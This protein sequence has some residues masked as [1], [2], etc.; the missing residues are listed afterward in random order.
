MPAPKNLYPPAPST[1]RGQASQLT[2]D[3]HHDRLGYVSLNN[4]VIRSATDPLSPALAYQE[5]TYRPTACRFSP[6]GGYMASG[7]LS[8]LVKVWS[9]DHEDLVLKMEVPCIGGAIKDVAWSGDNQRLVAV[10]DGSDK[11]GHAFILDTGTSVGEIG[12]H[13]KRI[14]TCDFKPTR[15]FRVVTGAED[16]QVNFHEGPPFK[17]KAL[18]RDHTRFVNCVRFSPD[19]AALLSVGSD[20]QGLI[21]DG[22]DFTRTG[23][24][25]T[26][27]AHKG[28]IF[29]CAWSLDGARVVTGSGDKTVKLWDAATG[30]C[31]GTYPVGAGAVRDMQVG[32]IFTKD[33]FVSL[34]LGG[35]LNFFDARVEGS[36][37][38]TAG[39]VRVLDGHQSAVVSLATTPGADTASSPFYSG[40]SDGAVRRDIS[41]TGTRGPLGGATMPQHGNS[42]VAVACTKDAAGEPVVVTA[43][44]D[45]SV[46]ATPAGAADA[47]GG[48]A[49]ASTFGTLGRTKLATAP[50]GAA[51]SGA[52][53]FVARIGAIDTVRGGNV[54]ASKDVAY[55]PLCIAVSPDGAQVAVGGDDNKVH[56]Y[57]VGA[58]DVLEDAGTLGD[59]KHRQQVTALAY[60]PDGARLASADAGRAIFVWNTASAECEIEGW[61]FHTS[62]VTSLAWAPA[63]VRLASGALDGDVY[64]WNAEEKSKRVHLKNA[65]K[66]GVNAVAWLSDTTVLSGGQD[67]CI[68]EWEV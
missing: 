29:S 54:A 56:L 42:V 11:F 26:A 10:G 51:C 16:N 21:F 37:A 25:D 50:A 53:T 61:V 48:S 44:L 40:G 13:G 41:G 6:S 33:N 32:V 24:L 55:Q 3:Q 27:D 14:N 63:G 64:I 7:D 36:T 8:G 38:S 19:G 59:V 15:P 68:R 60:T 1:E 45:D 67:G 18:N 23:Q 20:S 22:K 2:Y 28:S 58:A 39:P 5:H 43:S 4:V 35:D 34:S 46:A 30:K 62:R 57:G 66:N 52:T 12:G 31:L 47:D 65:H 17:F 49:A 9:P